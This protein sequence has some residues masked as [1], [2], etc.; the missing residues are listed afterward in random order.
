MVEAGSVDANKFKLR[1]IGRFP[2]HAA[3]DS[4]DPRTLGLDAISAVLLAGPD[5]DHLSLCG[6]VTMTESEC[7]TLVHALSRSID[8]DFSFED[9]TSPPA[10]AG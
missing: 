6:T 1:V 2:A 8:D 9:L 5:W 7:A 4:S 10:G 3:G